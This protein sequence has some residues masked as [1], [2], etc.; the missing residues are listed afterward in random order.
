[1]MYSRTSLTLHLLEAHKTGEGQVGQSS[2]VP[3]CDN[4]G[5]MQPEVHALLLYNFNQLV[6]S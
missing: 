6:L 1:M 2:T 3:G 4:A 5:S